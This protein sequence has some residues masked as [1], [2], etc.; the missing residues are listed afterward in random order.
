MY[1]TSMTLEIHRKL[2]IQCLRY[3][4]WASTSTEHWND[5]PIHYQENSDPLCTN[6]ICLTSLLVFPVSV[7]S[8][9]IG[10]ERYLERDEANDRRSFELAENCNQA[11][12]KLTQA[13][14][15]STKKSKKTEKPLRKR[16][17]FFGQ[18]WF[19]EMRVAA[20]TNLVEVPI[21]CVWNKQTRVG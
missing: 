8:K 15:V 14:E 11:M 5:K 7:R 21:W 18:K 4:I 10:S 9:C 1:S 3:C 6:D 12:S 17:I 19:S 2:G 16:W 13:L 20:S